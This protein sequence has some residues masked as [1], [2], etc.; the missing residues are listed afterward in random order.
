MKGV[1]P[2]QFLWKSYL[3]KLI[4]NYNI[5]EIVP[6]EANNEN[7]PYSLLYNFGN[8]CKETNNQ[9]PATTYDLHAF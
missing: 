1:P 2:H 8:G 9:P 7:Y 3:R 6:R 4:M 5:F